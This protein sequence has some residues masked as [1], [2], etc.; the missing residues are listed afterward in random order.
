MKKK[1]DFFLFQLHTNTPGAK[2]ED[3]LVSKTVV[4]IETLLIVCSIIIFDNDYF[5]YIQN[6]FHLDDS[7]GCGRLAY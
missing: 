6:T 1:K 7:V 3:K 2:T 5:D 4:N